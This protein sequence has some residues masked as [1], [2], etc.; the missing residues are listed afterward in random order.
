MQQYKDIL[1]IFP[2]T[3]AQLDIISRLFYKAGHFLVALVKNVFGIQC[4]QTLS[5][6]AFVNGL[7]TGD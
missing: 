6:I 3:S 7:A 5:S 2:G 1:L 4:L